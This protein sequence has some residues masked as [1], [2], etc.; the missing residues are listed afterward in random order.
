MLALYQQLILFTY[1]PQF[2]ECLQK[3]RIIRQTFFFKQLSKD[4]VEGKDQIK[5]EG[6]K[7]FKNLEKRTG[8]KIPARTGNTPSGD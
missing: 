1:K 3:G 4:G 8:K 6:T 5:L 7:G 2:C